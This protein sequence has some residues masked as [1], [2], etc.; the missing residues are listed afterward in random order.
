MINNKKFLNSLVYC[1]VV[2]LSA[3]SINNGGVPVFAQS[4]QMIAGQDF[5]TEV[6]S[7]DLPVLVEFYDNS[8]GAVS[9]VSRV[10]DEIAEQYSGQI[11]IVK[12]NAVENFDISNENGINSVPTFVL[13][14]EG[15]KMDSLVG[16][17]QK[18]AII[19]FLEKYLEKPKPE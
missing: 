9:K 19:E 10:V 18:Q 6:L 12:L 16:A 11:K 2:L 1:F 4:V 3:V 5:E 8:C 14:K 13:F 15:K 7:S 17:A